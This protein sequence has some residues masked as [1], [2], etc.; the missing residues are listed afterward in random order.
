MLFDSRRRLLEIPSTRKDGDAVWLADQ[1]AAADPAGTV[2]PMTVPGKE[3]ATFR[4][5]STAELLRTRVRET[6]KLPEASQRSAR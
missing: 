1:G 5:P 4:D 2:A 3:H 6:L